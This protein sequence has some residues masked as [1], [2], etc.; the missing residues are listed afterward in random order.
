MK[1]TYIILRPFPKITIGIDTV[2]KEEILAYIRQDEKH[3]SKFNTIIS[4]ISEGLNNR[5]LYKREKLSA[6]VKNV[7]AMRFFPGGD[8]DRIY[9]QELSIGGIK[10]I[11]LPELHLSKKERE[12]TQIEI[13]IIKKVS[14]YEYSQQQSG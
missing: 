11:V 13:K 6:E 12:N 10:I 7:T 8:N 5:H 14:N 3:K 4:I 9:C 1:R 2:N